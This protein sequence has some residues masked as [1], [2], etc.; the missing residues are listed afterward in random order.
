MTERIACPACGRPNSPTDA[1]CGAC[2]AT[3]RPPSVPPAPCWNCRAPNPPGRAYCGQCGQPLAAPA[4][5]A[6][7]RRRSNSVL[8]TL[9]VVAVAALGIV[10]GFLLLTLADDGGTGGPAA[11]PTAL[12]TSPA[13]LL[14]SP[15]GTLLPGSTPT[16]P[17][18]ATLPVV[19]SLGPP[20]EFGCYTQALAEG[21]AGTRWDLVRVHFRTQRGFDR[22]IYEL[23]LRERGADD[24]RPEVV[25]GQSIAGEGEFVG[26]PPW[27]P[28]A[29]ARINVVLAN[30]V[31][32]RAR[33]TEGYE[34]SGMRIVERLWTKRYRSHVNYIPPED[35]PRMADVGVLSNVDVLGAGCL[36]MRVLGWD[37]QGDDRAWVF[38]DVERESAIPNP[39]PAATPRPSSGPPSLVGPVPGPPTSYTCGPVPTTV[40][41]GR[42]SS[43]YRLY[44]V[45]F[46]TFRDYER[47]VLRLRRTGSGSGPPLAEARLLEPEA[48]DAT[49]LPPG[50]TAA[51]SMRLEGVSDGARLDGYQPRGM[52]IVEMVSTS[53]GGDTTYP[54]VLL[55]SDGCYRLRVPAWES[56][57]LGADHERV[58]VFIDFER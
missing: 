35:D 48:L 55:S 32:D 30:G 57:E 51:V 13:T 41:G 37:G 53:G 12:A 5:A 27:D 46:Q 47:V 38:V 44:E 56:S 42:D 10:T 15:E 21:P 9:L 50:V 7:D 45:G 28:D 49:A 6:S 8:L 31:R 3:L 18:T 24:L 58:D 39:P 14:P 54:N 36:A 40:Q 11:G 33:L 22:V 29:D 4:P 19:P 25:A 43:R 26:E 17:A 20:A 2:G 16:P 34:P 52:R 23:Q 1:Y